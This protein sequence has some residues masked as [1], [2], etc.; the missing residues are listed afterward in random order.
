MGYGNVFTAAPTDGVNKGSFVTA[1]ALS[2]LSRNHLAA[3]RPLCMDV[4]IR[5]PTG[6]SN[7]DVHPL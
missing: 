5:S 7:I 4:C 1:D 6:V 2:K 3:R